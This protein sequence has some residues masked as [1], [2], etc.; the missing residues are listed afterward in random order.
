MVYQYTSAISEVTFYITVE[1]FKKVAKLRNKIVL[2]HMYDA[3]PVDGQLYGIKVSLKHQEKDNYRIKIRTILGLPIS[4][5]V[6]VRGGGERIKEIGFHKYEG[7]FKI[8]DGVFK[9]MGRPGEAFEIEVTVGRLINENFD[10]I[11]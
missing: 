1:N 2:N 8:Y 4:G 10:M 7:Q 11:V 3:S 6:E 5:F 9:Y